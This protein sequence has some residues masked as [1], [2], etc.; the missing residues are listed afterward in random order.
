MGTISGDLHP[1]VHVFEK[2]GWR[3]AYMQV[4]AGRQAGKEGA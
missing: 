1:C 2:V 4:L 3:V